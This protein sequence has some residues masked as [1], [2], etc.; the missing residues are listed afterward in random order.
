MT[1]VRVPQ[2]DAQ[3]IRGLLAAHGIQSV[4]AGGDAE[5]WYPNLSFADGCPVQVFEDELEAARAVLEAA[6]ELVADD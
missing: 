6:P 4:V 5:G 2:A 1:L 3:V